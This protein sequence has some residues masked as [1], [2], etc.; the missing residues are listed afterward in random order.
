MLIMIVSLYFA[1]DLDGK[2][3]LFQSSNKQTKE[4]VKNDVL[5]RVDVK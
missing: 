1:E 3:F 5:Q 2:A 4:D